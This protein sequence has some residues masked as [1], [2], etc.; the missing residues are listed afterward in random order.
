[1]DDEDWSEYTEDDCSETSA[2][3]SMHAPTS[4]DG[5]PP[6]L[7]VD[8]TNET[9]TIDVEPGP[10]ARVYSSL[11]PNLHRRDSENLRRDALVTS[12][13]AL[14]LQ[15]SPSVETDAPVPPRRRSVCRVLTLILGMKPDREAHSQGISVRG[16]RFTSTLIH[17]LV[18]CG[19]NK[20]ELVNLMPLQVFF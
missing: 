13:T 16:Y 19:A 8:R 7:F 12:S 3:P 18:V 15:N 20:S 6:G 17:S 14:T 2:V 1:M 10:S 9:A 11:N 4:R 5:T